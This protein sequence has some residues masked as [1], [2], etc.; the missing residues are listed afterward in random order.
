M[1]ERYIFVIAALV[2]ECVTS[3]IF[4]AA[5][6]D[7]PLCVAFADLPNYFGQHA[8]LA[9]ILWL[10]LLGGSWVYYGP[11]ILRPRQ[12]LSTK[13]SFLA[14]LT[15]VGLVIDNL[16]SLFLLENSPEVVI[17]SASTTAIVSGFAERTLLYVATF[18]I[19][20]LFGFLIGR[21]QKPVV[22]PPPRFGR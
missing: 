19:V 5:S 20:V 18:S 13:L 6:P 4:Y 21:R 2:A 12:N 11:S 10:L 7:N 9:F 8:P 16:V 1:N 22:T 17:H 14:K 3:L 15:A